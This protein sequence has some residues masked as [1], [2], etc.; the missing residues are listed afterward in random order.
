MASVACRGPTEAFTALRV[1]VRETR[2]VGSVRSERPP[3]RS[4]SE[5]P[6]RVSV[7]ARVRNCA[8]PAPRAKEKAFHVSAPIFDRVSRDIA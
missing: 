4:R 5:S 1:S 6:A 8:R 3:R 2:R 7:R